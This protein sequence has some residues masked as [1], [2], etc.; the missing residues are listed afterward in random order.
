MESDDIY[1]RKIEPPEDMIFDLK[2]GR[3]WGDL[4]HIGVQ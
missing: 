2:S 3:D 4:I 1:Y